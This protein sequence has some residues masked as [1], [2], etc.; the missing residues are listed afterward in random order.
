L[1]PARVGFIPRL[2]GALTLAAALLSI[3]PAMAAAQK[4]GSRVLRPG[5]KGGDV[6]A[7]QH[8]LTQAGFRTPAIGLFGP[9]TERNV[10]T[11]QRRYGL[12][13]SG[14]ANPRFVRA[15]R[16]IVAADLNQSDVIRGSGGTGLTIGTTKPLQARHQAAPAATTAD[17]STVT[18]PVLAPVVQD[19]GSQHLG[20]RTLKLGMKGH[21]VRVLQSYLTLAGYATTVDGQ[22]GASTTTSVVAF[23]GASGLAADGVVTYPVSLALR[24]AVAKA[25]A[26]GPVATATINADGTATAPAGAPAIV[27]QVIAAANQ[28]IGKP[29]VYGGG[30]GS[31]NDV[32]YDCSGSVSYALHGG[33]LL[34]APDD[35]T[36]LESYGAAGPGKWITVYAN[37]GHTWVAVAG[38]AFDT[39][40]FGGPNIP[41]G[42]GPRWRTDPTGNLGD[43]TGGYVVRHPA[44]L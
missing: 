21:D 28:I 16:T 10:K 38:I 26:G 34:N 36:G 42:T 15:L 43:G 17:P 29:Y 1:S 25:T 9:V 23:Q 33:N 11:F 12:A 6:T 41:A 27:Q 31:F 8:E 39:A 32:G 19:G 37:S 5:M 40:D 13:V 22:F 30:H 14:V 4:L 35:S 3:A 20:E 7:L 2:L 24:Q 44:G 18:D